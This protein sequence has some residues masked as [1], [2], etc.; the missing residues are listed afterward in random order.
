MKRQGRTGSGRARGR[1]PYAALVL[2]WPYAADIDIPGRGLGAEAD[3]RLRAWLAGRDYRRGSSGGLE[4]ARYHFAV[5][6][7][8]DAFAAE[9]G[10]RRSA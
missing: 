2:S 4:V 10:G 8:A 6:A 1:L 7:D 9:F 3:T 5:E